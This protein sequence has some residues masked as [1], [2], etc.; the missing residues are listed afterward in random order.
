MVQT[1]YT[2]II[3]NHFEVQVMQLVYYVSVCVRMITNK[4]T[5]DLD[6]QRDGFGLS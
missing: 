2:K 6:I 1:I 3:T 5:F 4:M